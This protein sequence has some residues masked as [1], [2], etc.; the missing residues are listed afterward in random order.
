MQLAG[1]FVGT[2]FGSKN[3]MWIRYNSVLRLYFLIYKY[4]R[5]NL[6]FVFSSMFGQKF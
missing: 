4:L 2:R 1:V 3:S 6:T 5:T